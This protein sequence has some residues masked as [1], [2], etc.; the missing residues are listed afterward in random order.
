MTLPQGTLHRSI[1][2]IQEPLDEILDL[3]MMALIQEF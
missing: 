3:E 2:T 1:S